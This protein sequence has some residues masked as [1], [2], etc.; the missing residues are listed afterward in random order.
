MT[1]GLAQGEDRG[2]ARQIF[3]MRESHGARLHVL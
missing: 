2:E 1:V 3:L